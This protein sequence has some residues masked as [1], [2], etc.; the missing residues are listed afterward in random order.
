M[1]GTYGEFEKRTKGE[2]SLNACANTSRHAADAA[3]ERRIVIA[4]LSLPMPDS[5]LG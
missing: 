1:G 3:R 5:R 4:W 2:V